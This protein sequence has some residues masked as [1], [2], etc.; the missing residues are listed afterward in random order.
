MFERLKEWWTLNPEE[1]AKTADSVHEP[2]DDSKRRNALPLLIL[3]FTWGFLVTGLLIGGIIGPQMEFLTGTLPSILIGCLIIFLIGVLTG[4]VGYKIGGTNDMAFQYAYGTK[5]R[6]L[7]ATFVILAVMGFQGIIIGGT[8]TFW[9]KSTDHPAFFW[10]A[11]LVGLVFTYTCYVGIKFIEQFSNPSMI[12]LVGIS[13]YAIIYNISNAGGFGAFNAM[14]AEMANQAPDGPMSLAMGINIVIGSWITGA[15]LTSDFTRF[16]RTKWVAIGLIAM[17]FI[18]AQILLMVMGAIGAVISGTFD[19]TLYLYQV[20]PIVGFIALISMT[21]AMWTTSNTNLYLPATQV[22]SIF[23]RPFRVAVALCGLL[24]TFIGAFGFFTIFESFILWLAAIVPPL[25][26]PMIA[27]FWLVHRTKYS[28]D[29]YR[30]LPPV[31]KPAVIAALLGIVATIAS[32]GFASLGIP[33]VPA[34]AQPWIVPA[35]FG[36]FVSLASY[37][38]L[39]GLFKAAGSAQGYAKAVENQLKGGGAM[40]GVNVQG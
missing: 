21:I 27:D 28:A 38:I 20:S 24:G 40:E 11:L 3:G 5:G 29:T 6:W 7:P 30:Y 15:V 37:L 12:L 32:S 19:F 2:L 33:P 18:A 34:L 31:N 17:N 14:S 9:L 26:G 35:V 23:K 16:A 1:E 8:A 39:Y 25:A 4:L 13:I 36:L 10:V 22:A